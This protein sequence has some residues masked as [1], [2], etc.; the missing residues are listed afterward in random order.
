MKPHVVYYFDAKM[1]SESSSEVEWEDVEPLRG[2]AKAR[3][4]AGSLPSHRGVFCCL[5][6]SRGKLL[7]G[8]RSEGRLRLFYRTT[9]LSG[10]ERGNLVV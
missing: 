10:R 3:V 4:M 9:A 1:S 6:Q 5:F 8:P 2:E 7:W